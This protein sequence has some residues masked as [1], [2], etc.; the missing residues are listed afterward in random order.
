MVRRGERIYPLAVLTL[1]LFVG[2]TLLGIA[3]STLTSTGNLSDFFYNLFLVQAWGVTDHLSFNSPAWSISA[4]LFC[5]ILF[6][7][8]M[9]IATS[10]SP[11]WLAAIV[12]VTYRALAHGSLPLWHQRSQMYGANFD[13]GMLRALPSFLNGLLLV[14]FFKRVVVRRKPI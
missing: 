1:F 13:F 14:M 4:E 10:V 2:L 9:L 12:A 5:Y 3:D 11:L 8:L 6:P 7:V